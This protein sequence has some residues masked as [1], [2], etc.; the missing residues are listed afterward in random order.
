[1]ADKWYALFFPFPFREWRAVLLDS[2]KYPTAESVVYRTLVR[3]DIKE[4][5]SFASEVLAREWV[6]N[7]VD[8]TKEQVAAVPFV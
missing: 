7:P 5:R 2:T 4:S 1:M 3:S 8:V 6:E